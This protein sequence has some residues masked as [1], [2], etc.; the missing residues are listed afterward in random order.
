MGPVPVKGSAVA[1]A[2]AASANKYVV[3]PCESTPA[4]EA[5]IVVD[6]LPKGAAR[7]SNAGAGDAAATAFMS[8]CRLRED[9][10][11]NIEW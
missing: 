5:D 4:M 9:G 8:V 2:E 3:R 10:R 1:D 6:S 11:T 7:V